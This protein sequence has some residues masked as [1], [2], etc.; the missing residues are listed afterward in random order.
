MSLAD[1]GRTWS[2]VVSLSTLWLLLPLLQSLASALLHG[3]SS[4]VTPLNFS[5]HS[6]PSCSADTLSQDAWACDLARAEHLLRHGRSCPSHPPPLAPQPSCLVLRNAS[7]RDI[8]HMSASNRS[9]LTRQ[10]TLTFCHKYS[11]DVLL[12][13]HDWMQEREESACERLLHPHIL[14]L[15]DRDMQAASLACEF[16][17]LLSRYN[18]HTGYT[19]GYSVKWNCS[20][21]IVSP[22]LLQRLLP[23]LSH[24][25]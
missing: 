5:A 10:L 11:L 14:H 4:V 21:C 25:H 6:T 18:C 2:L 20:Q 9:Q 19:G 13:S 17:V 1:E 23:S 24:P 7:T 15:L 22:I 3:H 16:D 8:C 12:R